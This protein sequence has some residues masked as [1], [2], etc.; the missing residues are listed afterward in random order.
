VNSISASE[1]RATGSKF[2]IGG[3]AAVVLILLITAVVMFANLPDANTFNAR[4]EQIFVEND[5]FTSQAELKLLEILAQS[6]TAFSDTIASYQV[7]IY[8]LLVFHWLY[9]Q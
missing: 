4:V 6:G 3:I 5:D 1:T 2:V 7:L 9:N 8:V